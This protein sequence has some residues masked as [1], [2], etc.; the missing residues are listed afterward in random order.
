MPDTLQNWEPQDWGNI[1][2]NLEKVRER[3][4]T[5]SAEL[6]SSGERPGES[7]KLKT[8]AV[9]QAKL[10]EFTALLHAQ[11]LRAA[12]AESEPVPEL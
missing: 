10:V 7:E 11:L 8:L 4:D 1:F 12:N 9:Q 2:S 3:Q 6:I 5:L